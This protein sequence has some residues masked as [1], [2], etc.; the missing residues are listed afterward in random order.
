MMAKL[1]Y[2]EVKIAEERLRSLFESHGLV[3]IEREITF[4]DR[5]VPAGDGFIDTLGLD[6][7]LRP[8]IIE[9]KV[10]KEASADALVQALSYSYHIANDQEYYAKLFKQKLPKRKDIDFDNV[11][12]VIVAPEFSRHVVDAA[13]AGQV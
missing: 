2:T 6:E 11:R 9:Y 4:V 5:N 12:I 3:F 7:Q 1:E 10:N 8:V 13:K